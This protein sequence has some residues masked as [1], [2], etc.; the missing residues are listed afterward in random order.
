MPEA[1]GSAPPRPNIV[2]I[3]CDDMGFS[4]IGCFGSEIRTPHLDGLARRGVC[5]TQV[6]N[7]GRC[8][9][10]R[11]SLLTGLYP[12][13]AGVGDMVQDRGVEAYQGFLNDRCV[14]IAELLRAAGYRTLMTGKWHVGGSWPRRP[15]PEW[16]VHDPRKPLPPDRGFDD[17]YGIPGGGS[18][19]QPSPLMRNYEFVRLDADEDFYTTDAYTDAAVAMVRGA[20]AAGRPFFLHVCYNAP[21]WPLHARAEDIARYRGTYAGGWD[22][23]RTARHERLK[24]LGVLS[25]QWPI[26]PRDAEAPPWREVDHHDW[27]DARMAVYAA[28]I[29]RMDQGIG[30]IL[31]CL[32]ELG[33]EDD[34]LVLFLS[35]NGGSAEFLAE[36]GRKEAELPSTRDGREVRV[37]NVVGLVPGGPDTFQSYGRPWANVSNAPFRLFKHWVHEGGI[38]TPL[39]A[40]WPRGIRQGGLVHEPAHVVDVAATCLAVAGVPYPAEFAGRPITPPAGEDFSAVFAGRPW[41][42]TQPIFWEHEGNRAVRMG[43]WKLVSQ[44]EKGAWELYDMAEDRTELN[45][46]AASHDGKARELAAAYEDWARCCGVLPWDQVRALRR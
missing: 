15:G 2:L 34:T 20:A 23:V 5:F 12:H 6:Y 38:A 30:R 39:I 25:S 32:R 11:A 19:F 42:R 45:D 8:C 21:H 44:Y 13:Q 1:D 27:Q 36:N 46:L 17:W 35:D 31:A 3:L 16:R 24:G 41:R 28:Q 29:D 10:T 7:C 33:I 14:T 40:F 9:P 4:D 22:Q 18:Y 37:G 26:S 43:R